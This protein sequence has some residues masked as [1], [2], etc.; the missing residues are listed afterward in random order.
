MNQGRLDT[1]FDVIVIG[2]GPAGLAAAIAAKTQGADGVLVIDREI[3][4]GGIPVSFAIFSSLEFKVAFIIYSKLSGGPSGPD[5][6][7][8]WDIPSRFPTA[9]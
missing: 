2:A 5:D 7:E 1:E 4:A 6:P 9:P 3:E 8:K